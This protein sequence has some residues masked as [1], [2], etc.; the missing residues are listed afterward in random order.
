M[1]QLQDSVGDL[2]KSRAKRIEALERQTR[3][4]DDELKREIDHLRSQHEALAKTVQE[5]ASEFRKAIDPQDQ[6]LQTLGTTVRDN[7]EQLE[8]KVEALKRESRQ[9]DDDLMNELRRIV[10]RLDNQKTDRKALAG[11]LMDVATRLETDDSVTELLEGLTSSI[12][13]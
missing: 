13:E 5:N 9:A 11:M 12:Q 4:T 10:G 8:R 7:R 3:Q 6:N 2:E 1:R